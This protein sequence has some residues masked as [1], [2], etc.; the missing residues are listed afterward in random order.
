MCLAV[1]LAACPGL[2]LF[3]PMCGDCEC[4][5]VDTDVDSCVFGVSRHSRVSSPKSASCDVEIV[6]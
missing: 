6:F 3:S 2:T 4:C 1:R 5:R